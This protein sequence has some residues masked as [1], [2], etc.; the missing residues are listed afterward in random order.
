[1][2]ALT[3]NFHELL[4][5]IPRGAWVAVASDQER[6]VAYGADM[7]EVLEEARELGEQDPIIFRIPESE[8]AL[9]L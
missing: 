6:V 1:M 5:S 7:R 3:M 2:A 8:S 4:K 9:I